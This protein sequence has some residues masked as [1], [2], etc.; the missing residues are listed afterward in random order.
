MTTARA[1]FSPSMRA[2]AS[3]AWL[4]QLPGEPEEEREALEGPSQARQAMLLDV[5]R[6]I[7]L[8]PLGF[9]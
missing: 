3:S 2:I 5:P 6:G 7:S 9:S 8:G 4:A 1:A